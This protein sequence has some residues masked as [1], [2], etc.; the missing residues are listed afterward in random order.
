MKRREFISLLGGAAAAWPMVART[1]KAEPV[2]RIGML[3]AG[4]ESDREAQRR[5]AA[6]R[7]ELQ[8]IGWAEPRNIWI[9]MR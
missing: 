2:R 4:S 3:I 6:F 1:Q 9:D 7:D 5:V 8:N